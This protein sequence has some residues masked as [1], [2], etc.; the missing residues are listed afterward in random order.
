[1]T[2]RFHICPVKLCETLTPW[3]AISA[4]V[5]AAFLLVATA[6]IFD[7]DPMGKPIVLFGIGAG[8]WA[9][10]LEK[11]K[12]VLLLSSCPDCGWVARTTPSR[13]STASSRKERKKKS[14]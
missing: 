2:C 4:G 13:L 14:N 5:V 7:F 12:Y 3:L 11:D 6:A 1:M 10:L 8:V 9:L